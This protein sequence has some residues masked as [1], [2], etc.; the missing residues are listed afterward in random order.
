MKLIVNKCG[1]DDASGFAGVS[2]ISNFAPQVRR[3]TYQNRATL[4]VPVVMLRQAV[5]NGAFVSKDQLHPE[6]W[7]GV[8]VTLR[9][10]SNDDDEFVSAND[11]V[12]LEKFSV[13]RIFN[14]HI[15]GD[16]LKGEA[17]I[18]I[19][20]ANSVYPGIVAMLES[21]KPMDV[22]TGYFALRDNTDGTYLG[23]QYKVKHHDLKPDHLALL[24][25]ESGA[26]SWLDGCGVRANMEVDTMNVKEFVAL[27][28]NTIGG[29]ESETIINELIGNTAA[30]FVEPDRESLR[31]MRKEVLAGLKTTYLKGETMST[32]PK[33]FVAAEL[34]AAG[35]D[36][37]AIARIIAASAEPPKEKTAAEIAAEKAASDA[38]IAAGKQPLPATVAEMN[39]LIANGV[40]AALKTAMPLAL[41]ESRRP[42]LLVKV[43][44]H[45]AHT[46]EAAEKMDTATLE[47]IVAGLKPVAVAGVRNFS[48]RQVPNAGKSGDD[49]AKFAKSMVPL[50]MADY[51]ANQNAAKVAANAG[52]K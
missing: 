12:A 37:A 16:K 42:E 30:P 10:P 33:P 23:K 20:K 24:P 3:T 49:D 14:S 40:V 36:D 39:A 17:W 6:S 22:S 29:N 35:Y 38:A 31:A 27:I 2:I 1:C 48:G 32:K 15:D 44:A 47:I 4:I 50:S 25:D 8:P 26:C 41:A 45:T 18:D 28:T 19:E 34:K 11:P 5:V 9:H 43:I 13:G 51:V 21:G 7:N 52:V 46:K